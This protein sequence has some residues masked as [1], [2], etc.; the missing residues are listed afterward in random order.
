MR[1]SLTTLKRILQEGDPKLLERLSADLVSKLVGVRFTVAKA[2]F[3]Y[4]SDAGSTGRAG[5]HLRLECKRYADE[6][7]LDDRNLQG[8]ID[9]ALRRDPGLEAWI[10]FSTRGVPQQTEDTLYAKSQTTGVPV[11]VI[12][13]RENSAEMP[14]LAGLCA[15]APEIVGK[16]YG[17]AAMAAARAIKPLART[18]VEGL[19]RELSPW[20]I[21]YDSLRHSAKERI[22]KLWRN[23]AESRSVF[24][25]NVAGSLVPLVPRQS[26]SSGLEAWWLSDSRSVAV[27]FGA[28]GMGKTWATVQWAKES[29]NALPIVLMLPSSAFKEL[30][31]LTHASIL[32]FLGTALHDLNPGT[33]RT[34]WH[35]RIERLLQRP[36][37]EG[38]ALFILVDGINQE[39]SFEWERFFQVLEGD[40]FSRRVRIVITSQTHFLQ[41]RLHNLRRLSHTPSRHEV[42]RY[43]LSRGGEF[44]TLLKAHGLIRDQLPSSVIELARVPRMFELTIRQMTDAALQGEP[45]PSR[46][47]YAHARDELGLKARGALSEREW[48]EWLEMLATRYREEIGVRGLQYEDNRGYSTR[49][50]GDMVRDP[51]GSADETARR[52]HEI[53]SG[54]WLEPMPGNPGRF[55]PTEAT[56][57]LALAV[58]IL[59]A[60]EAAEHQSSERASQLLDEYL[61]AVRATPVATDVLTAALSVVVEKRLRPGSTIAKLIL[62]ALLNSQNASDE[63]RRQAMNLAPALVEPLLDVAEES[64]SRAT[65]SARHWALA[66]LRSVRETNTAAWELVINRMVLWVAHASCPSTIKVDAGDESATHRAKLLKERIG[67]SMPGV[68][69]V[70]GVPLRLDERNSTDLGNHIPRLLL[71]KSLVSA[72]KV[73][74]AAAVA[75]SVGHAGRTWSGLKWLVMLNPVDRVE[76]KEEL[77]R[78]SSAAL[79]LVREQGIKISFAESVSG[80]LLWLTGDEQLERRAND[81]RTLHPKFGYEKSY[82]DNPARSFFEL[83]HRHISLLWADKN[84]SAFGKLQRAHNFLPDPGLVFPMS[85]VKGVKSWGKSLKSELVSSGRNYSAEDHN[86]DRFMRY[87]VRVSP[88]SVQ[89]IVGRWF[90]TFGSR[91]DE[92]RH[93]AAVN[94]PRYALLTGPIEE[95]A[96]R[97]MRLRPSISPGKD[98]RVVL[99]CLLEAELINAATDVQLDTL[100][101]AKDAFISL[102][103]ASLL[104]APAENTVDEYVYRWGL[105]NSRAVE[106]LCTYLWMHPTQLQEQTFRGL[107]KH[108]LGDNEEQRTLAFMALSVCSPERFGEE[109]LR[110]GWRA[111]PSAHEYLQDAGSQAIFAA[112]KDADLI[113]LAGLV[114]P[115]CL[116]DEAVS[117]GRSAPD[118]TVAAQAISTTLL[119]N[120]IS[121]FPTEARISVESAGA[122]S[123][124]SVE[125]SQQAFNDDE[126]L[127]S[128]DP[129]MRTSRHQSARETGETFLRNAKSAGAVMATRVVSVEAARML[130]EHCPSTVSTWLEGIEGA[131]HAFVSRLNAAGG[132]FL[133]L[134]EALLETHPSRGV[135]LWAE[136]RKHLRIR[137]VGIAKL[138]ELLLMVFRVPE[139][140]PVLDLRAQLYGLS[141]NLNDESYLDLAVAAVSQ[142]CVNWLESA[143]AAD[144]ASG[145]PFREKRAI[146]IRGFLPPEQTFRPQWREGQLVGTWDAQRIRAQGSKNRAC[147]ARYWWNA[148]LAARDTLGAFCA[149][150]V[151]LSC[152]DKMAWTWINSDL[153]NYQADDELW[154]LKMLHWRLNTSALNSAMHDKV[155]TGAEAL[156]KNL[157]GWDSPSGWFEPNEIGGLG[158]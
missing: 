36:L 54:A 132:L 138:D 98:E 124:V 78:L 12:D 73:L 75:A 48:E 68:H 94:T 122:R 87:A 108:A 70:L 157:V 110:A 95:A 128:L 123:L 136:L 112:L 137:F 7:P 133:A 29:L 42:G 32:E 125:A 56:I 150:H 65:A 127:M 10:L 139:S 6:S 47:L 40:A 80:L 155:S 43:D 33:A 97:A 4:G 115:W 17:K 25:Q 51:A 151:F 89:D 23:A 118:A 62:S 82:L 11:V 14:V 85:L 77:E 146:T 18:V 61:D 76:L 31:G 15:W 143:I 107:L 28:E 26:V 156:S 114:A 41:E 74:V 109:L 5:R 1:R 121:R 141:Q 64:H 99:M 38:A 81:R 147:F 30:R 120:G 49:E 45:T 100:V 158:Y 134:C 79:G 142:N 149:W 117:R 144:A 90:Q 140:P 63:Q 21:G 126:G 92:R 16:H 153:K 102:S 66:S 2:G 116:L 103:L 58:A 91:V 67:T 145:I 37:E 35:A 111:L 9:D 104:R 24:G 152:A 71:G 44:D 46:L 39:P 19:V 3:Q 88:E 8:E 101:T 22:E 119:W 72:R 57:H 154:R 84:F 131:T 93:W 59:G 105:E 129:E 135:Q 52:L 148:F 96:I 130:V 34:Y 20:A 106:V 27:V 13:W 86:L 53:V 60:L 83:E 50:L 69:T 113:E 55:R